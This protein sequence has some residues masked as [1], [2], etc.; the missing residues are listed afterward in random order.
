[1]PVRATDDCLEYQIFQDFRI[2]ARLFTAGYLASGAMDTREASRYPERG[3]FMAIQRV[4]IGCPVRE[5]SS[6]LRA[7]LISLK[8][9][10]HKDFLIDYVFV[11]DNEK[12]T[13]RQLLSAF[14]RDGSSVTVLP[15]VKGKTETSEITDIRDETR[16]VRVAG[17]RNRI[18]RYALQHDYDGL[19]LVDSDLILH[20]QL[21]EYLRASG[22]KAVSELFWIKNRLGTLSRPNAWLMEKRA[23]DS[24]SRNAAMYKKEA[25]RRKQKFS[26]CLKTS[27]IYQAGG[28][29]ACTYLDREALTGGLRFTPAPN[30]DSHDK[31]IFFCLQS[32]SPDLT[33]YVDTAYP[34]YHI[35]LDKDLEGALDYIRKSRS[36]QLTFK[37][38]IINSFRYKLETPAMV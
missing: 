15:A 13:S 27:G 12:E 5:K 3:G 6:I 28:L 9:L 29:G 17:Y 4:L 1:M 38:P 36:T 34:A 24:D 26:N 19:F 25:E 2:N 14:K 16:L 35:H 32:S 22:K 30:P 20:P 10:L 33:L 7:F 31:D 37:E 8:S 18:I 23:L 21:L 11:D